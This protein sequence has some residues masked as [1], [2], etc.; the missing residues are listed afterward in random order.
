M[1]S[2]LVNPTLGRYC[3]QERLNHNVAIATE[4]AE[5]TPDIGAIEVWY[6]ETDDF[7][8]IRFNLGGISY[9]IHSYKIFAVY[10]EGVDSDKD[11]STYTRF[12]ASYAMIDWF[13]GGCQDRD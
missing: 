10:R 6:D 12:G 3:S 2:I 8:K 9:R 5:R 13:V 7:V 11:R 1:Q 4:I